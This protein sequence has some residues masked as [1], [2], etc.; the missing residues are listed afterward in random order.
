[1]RSRSAAL[2][3]L[4]VAGAC[5]LETDVLGPTPALCPASFTDCG[6]MCVQLAL[7]RNNCGACGVRC[8]EG[9]ECASGR[10]ELECGGGTSKCG[11]GCVDTKTDPAN[12]GS[13]G[14][15]CAKDDVCSTGKCSFECAGGTTECSDKCVDMQLD[16][17]NCGGC[18]AACAP[19]EVCSTGMCAIECAG[20]TSKCSD[21][22][23][24]VQLDPQNCGGCGN[25]CGPGL[26]CIMAGC[27]EPGGH[28][29]SKGFGSSGGDQGRAVALDANGNALVA[30]LFSGTV[31]FGG[32][33]LVSAGGH[34]IFVLKLAP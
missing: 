21:K 4:L 10:C 29:W 18:G 30:G 33:P 19:G 31:D 22:C 24:D 12:C 2:G 17:A 3:A 26:T 25:A 20:G 13:C 6:G 9:E 28:L 27:R 23:V 11:E 5:M 8:A 34:D 14:K 7:D 1:M 15:A 16:P 32:G